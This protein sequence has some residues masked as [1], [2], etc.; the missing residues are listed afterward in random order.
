MKTRR[1]KLASIYARGRTYRIKYYK[2]GLSFRESSHSD[3]YDEAERLLK[4][5]NGEIVTGKFAGLGPERVR[6]ADLFDDLLVDY[7]INRRNSIVQLT[8]RLKKHLIPAFGQLRAADF[9]THD[10]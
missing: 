6:M 10:V 9:T 1:P 8:S 7:R 5:R 2:S 3:S 4:Q